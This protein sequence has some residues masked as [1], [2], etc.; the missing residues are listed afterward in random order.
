MRWITLMILF[1]TTA[2]AAGCGDNGTCP[3]ETD[4]NPPGP[5]LFYPLD[6]GNTW[7]YRSFFSLRF[8]DPDS[9]V[10]LRA[11]TTDAFWDV[12]LTCNETIGGVE[13]VVETTVVTVDTNTDTTWVRLRQDTTGLYRA[14]I[15]RRI[16]PGSTAIA[17]IADPPPERVRLRYALEAGAQW[18]VITGMNPVTATVE[19]ADTIDTPAG[20]L[21]AW[22]IRIDTPVDGAA[23]YH[24]VWQSHNGKIQEEEYT[25]F[26]AVDDFTG[27][28]VRIVTDSRLYLQ[29]SSLSGQHLISAENSVK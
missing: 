23:D 11:D 8:Y 14:D 19:G 5:S 26:I 17:G 12:S 24:Y 4:E 21:P 13:Y 15:P 28:R 20:A 29:S 16:R 25:E 27:E 22:R 6:I 9:G 3:C 1:L 7:A 10:L 2:F 18:D